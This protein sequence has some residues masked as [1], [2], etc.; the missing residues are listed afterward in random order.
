MPK[1]ELT[2][3]SVEDM[4]QTLYA[5]RMREADEGK[6]AELLQQINE[7]KAMKASQI[8]QAAHNMAVLDAA[9]NR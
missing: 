1:K 5:Q 7:L 3:Q 9:N 2:P 8:N 6:R 4:I